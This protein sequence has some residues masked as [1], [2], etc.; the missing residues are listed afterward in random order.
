[1]PPSSNHRESCTTGDPIW[2][3]LETSLIKPAREAGEDVDIRSDRRERSSNTSTPPTAAPAPPKSQRDHL[4]SP[5]HR[6]RHGQSTGLL[7]RATG[8]LEQR[9]HR[10]APLPRSSGQSPRSP[11]ADAAATMALRR[12][13]IHVT[14]LINSPSWRP[15]S[16][17]G[18]RPVTRATR[19]GLVTRAGPVRAQA[20]H[21]PG[22]VRVHHAEPL[23]IQVACLEPTS[24]VRGA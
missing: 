16:R 7:R 11:Y 3:A 2:L 22:P 21:L 5:L 12:D 6:P 14:A 10:R 9:K 17:P 1:M 18:P 24:S 13:A 15:W 20:V 8:C 23:V 4:P 19:S